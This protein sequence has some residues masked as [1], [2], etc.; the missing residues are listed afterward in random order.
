MATSSRFDIRP[1]LLVTATIVYS[2]WLISPLLGTPTLITR[3]Y[4][5]ELSAVDQ[6]FSE[7][8]RFADGLTGFMLILIGLLGFVMSRYMPTRSAGL[9]LSAGC[10]APSASPSQSAHNPQ[11]RALQHRTPQHRG[12]HS[13]EARPR[14]AAVITAFHFG[15]V[16]FGVFTIADVISPLHCVASIDPMCLAQQDANLLPLAHTVHSWTSVLASAGMVTAM[17]AD[18]WLRSGKVRVALTVATVIM[19][20]A[21]AAGDFGWHPYIGIVQ[22]LQLIFSAAWMLLV[23]R[24]MRQ[25]T[26]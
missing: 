20:L 18:A 22:R 12:P 14:R 3:S 10:A 4:V 23:A 16:A 11:S 15:F 25:G 17:V 5:S 24:A 2:L 9:A 21:T 19:L 6:E 1:Y 26:R 13:A 8:F 7:L